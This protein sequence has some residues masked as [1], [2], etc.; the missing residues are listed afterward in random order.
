MILG[1]PVPPVAQQVE[2]SHKG[3]SRDNDQ[4]RDQKLRGAGV[5]M[6]AFEI[7]MGEPQL[8]H[9]QILAHQRSHHRT[10]VDLSYSR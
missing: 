4:P 8:C 2:M 10:S 5:F 9:T 3:V 1:L 7:D 6:Q